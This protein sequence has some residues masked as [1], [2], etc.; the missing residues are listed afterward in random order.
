MGR[1]SIKS[2]RGTAA[3]YAA[4]GGRFLVD[5]SRYLILNDGQS[6]EIHVEGEPVAVSFCVF[7]PPGFV[8]ELQRSLTAGPSQLLDAPLAEGLPALRFFERTY[9]HD[10]LVSPALRRLEAGYAARKHDPGWLEEGLHD[11]A[12]RLLERHRATRAEAGLLAAVRASTRE[13]LYRRLHRARD[14]ARSCYDRALSLGELSRVACLSPNHLLR[15]YRRLFGRTPH[16]ELIERRLEV[17]R[18]LLRRTDRPVTEVCAA[19]GFESLGSFSRTFSRRVGASPLAY[20]GAQKV[21]SEKQPR[22][23]PATFRV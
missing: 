17:A 22:A 4:G 9:P 14:Y 15:H 21:I 11:L 5:D 2:F 1:L 8:E 7:F 23:G 10:D 12:E 20:R 13:E 6:Y 19:V 3:H 18:E 16:Q